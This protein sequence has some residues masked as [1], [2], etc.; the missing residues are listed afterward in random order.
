MAISKVAEYVKEHPNTLMR[1]I[2]KY[3]DKSEIVA[4]YSDIV[5][6][7]IDETASKRGHKYITSMID[8]DK[9]KVC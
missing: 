1:I 7:G 2:K 8:I 6:I 4:D 9:K 3:V 5:R